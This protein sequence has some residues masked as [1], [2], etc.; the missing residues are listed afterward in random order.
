[1]K[2]N[3]QLTKQAFLLT[4]ALVASGAAAQAQSADALIDKLVNKGILTADEAQELRAQ[5]DEGFTAAYKAKTGMPEY[6]DAMRFKGDF[7]GRYEGFFKDTPGFVDR[8]RFRY[9]V[10]FGVTID[11]MDDFEVG[12]RLGSGDISGINAGISGV[13]PISNNQTFQDNG[14]KKGIFIDLAY[15]TWRPLKGPIWSSSTTIGKMNNPFVFSSM[16]FDSDYS[17]EGVAQGIGYRVNDIHTLNSAFGAFVLDE[18]GGS[19]RDPY[20]FGGQVRLESSWN[21]DWK[22]SFGVAMLSVINRDRLRNND[23]LNINVGND[24]DPVTTAPVYA[25]NT[26]VVDGALTYTIENGIPMYNAKF[27]IT[28]AADYL[29]NNSAAED[30]TGYSV[31]I[32]FGKSG[33]RG[34]WDVGYTYK[35]LEGNA[36]YEEFLNSDSG[37]YYPSALANSGQGIGYRA[38][39]NIKG[40]EVKV[41]Y[42]PFDAITFGL[43][44]YFLEAV[45]PTPGPGGSDIVRVQADA[46][47]KF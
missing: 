19:S 2:P 3:N 21:A 23:V 7:R 20:L 36:W 43:A 34:L 31:G 15:A 16:V 12:F 1:M 18:V 6:V 35:H 42:S 47:L 26:V 38:G 32:Q 37:A 45:N 27:P 24:R 11:L 46:Q 40:H 41:Q 22:S 9:R 4:G 28:L 5:S 17:P 25:F 33:K 8:N 10:R 14:A 29:H 30:G 44:G 39:T 13:D